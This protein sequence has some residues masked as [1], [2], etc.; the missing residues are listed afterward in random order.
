MIQFVLTREYFNHL[1]TFGELRE[2]E[3]GFRCKTIERIPP[4]MGDTPTQ[5]SKKARPCGVYDL[6]HVYLPM[7]NRNTFELIKAG[8]YSKA[9][10]QMI[11]LQNAGDIVLARATNGTLY[12]AESEVVLNVVDRFIMEKIMSGEL[13]SRPR[14]GYVQLLITEDAGYGKVLPSKESL[15]QEREEEPVNWDLVDDDWWDNL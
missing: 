12:A 15:Q 7:E 2:P 10:F 9:C 4:K 6:R 14:R 11:R 8:V 1:A 3:T 5:R 13:P